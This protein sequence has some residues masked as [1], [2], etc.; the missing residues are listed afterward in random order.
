M[1]FWQPVLE[2]S[3]I[4]KFYTFVCLL[5]EW[6]ATVKPE[7]N[8]GPPGGSCLLVTE[9]FISCDH[10]HFNNCYKDIKK[11]RNNNRKWNLEATQI[12]SLLAKFKVHITSLY[13]IVEP[14]WFT[15]Y[16]E[17]LDSDNNHINHYDRSKPH[18]A[19]PLPIC[20][21]VALCWFILTYPKVSA[22]ICWFL[23]F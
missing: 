7:W 23:L 20:S 21:F 5:E 17:I 11:K 14:Q 12:V 16:S 2:K 8:N 22:R 4:S 10:Y 13:V 9:K 6:L 1:W 18:R 3:V 15:L 19:L